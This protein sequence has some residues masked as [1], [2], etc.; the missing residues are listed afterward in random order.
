V[1]PT[2]DPLTIKLEEKEMKE[3]EISK[4]KDL[5]AKLKTQKEFVIDTLLMFKDLSISKLMPTAGYWQGF[6]T[7]SSTT[8][9]LE[10]KGNYQKGGYK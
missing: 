1:R 5:L 4:F 8:K 10:S 2:K 9:V 7:R 6:K 3:E